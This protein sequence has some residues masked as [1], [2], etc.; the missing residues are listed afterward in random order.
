MVITGTL[1]AVTAL[2]VK[3][4][5]ARPTGA[6]PAPLQQ[7]FNGMPEY[8][9]SVASRHQE[10]IRTQCANR[11]LT[12]PAVHSD[13]VGRGGGR[14]KWAGKQKGNEEEENRESQ[15][16]EEDEKEMAGDRE[17][18]QKYDKEREE[19]KKEEGEEDG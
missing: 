11:V 9:D 5:Q 4:D 6:A 1:L 17:G 16:E 12:A 10:P 8:G 7:V 15:L 3:S 18:K 2:Q 13:L 14:W 19:K